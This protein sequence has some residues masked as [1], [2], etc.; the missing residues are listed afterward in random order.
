MTQRLEDKVALIT[1]ASSG[2]GRAVCELFAQEGAAVVAVARREEQGRAVVEAIK[3]SGGRAMFIR[4]D[5]SIAKDCAAMVEK[6]EI[7]FGGLDIA[8]NN[9]GIGSNGK[10]V[11]DET[12][13]EW[14][15][16]IATNLKGVFLSMKYEIPALLRRGGGTIINTSSVGGL[17]GGAGMASYQS[18]KHAVLGLTKCAA[19]EY[20]KKNIRVNAVCP[21][22]TQTEMVD[23]WFQRPGVAERITAA[24]PIGRIA[25]AEEIAKGVLFLAS[26]D[27]SFVLGHSL[28][29][30]GGFVIQ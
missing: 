21:A 13:E 14:D 20:A 6:A 30:D 22:A 15:R 19:L 26:D 1:G 11:V 9:A 25:T 10:F 29:M 18:S 27:A 28:V 23:R 2:I 5:V 12:E 8:F 4:G 16:V 17:I 24:H 3:K 7:E